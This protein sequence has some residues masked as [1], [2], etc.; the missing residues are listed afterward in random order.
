MY[1]HTHTYT[2]VYSHTY[3]YIYMYTYVHLCAYTRVCTHTYTYMYWTWSLSQQQKV[4][5]S[6]FYKH[7]LFIGYSHFL[8]ISFPTSFRSS[9]SKP[10]TRVPSGMASVDL[11][12]FGKIMFCHFL[13][14]KSCAW[15]F[16][17]PSLACNLSHFG[18]FQTGS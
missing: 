18:M 16:I 15:Y 11:L 17:Q 13:F 7:Y 3:T 9:L 14:S 6:I 5:T 4:D 8:Q 2:Y 12:L 10:N 1:V